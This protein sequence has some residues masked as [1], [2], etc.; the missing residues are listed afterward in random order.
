MDAADSASAGSDAEAPNPPPVGL[1]DLYTTPG[2]FYWSRFLR[3]SL[4]SIVVL[5]TPRTMAKPDFENLFALRSYVE[6][7][8]AGIYHTCDFS[9]LYCALSLGIYLTSIFIP[10]AKCRGV[11]VGTRIPSFSEDMPIGLDHGVSGVRMAVN[12][13]SRVG[14]QTPEAIAV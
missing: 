8:F 4:C 11:T 6:Y 1:G 13:R 14:A 5:G 7:K 3:G 2:G 9:A 10:S 12:N